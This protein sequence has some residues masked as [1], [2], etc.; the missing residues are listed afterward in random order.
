[1]VPYSAG[2]GTEKSG[3]TEPSEEQNDE[4]HETA[5][6]EKQESPS[7][8]ESKAEGPPGRQPSIKFPQRM[9]DGQRISEMPE[10]DRPG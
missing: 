1:M 2:E 4:H 3:S 7:E 10:S 9:A 6:Q 5:S 8:E